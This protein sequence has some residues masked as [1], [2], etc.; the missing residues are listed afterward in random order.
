MS[1][2]KHP[3]PQ[4]LEDMR[5]IYRNPGPEWLKDATGTEKALRE[6]LRDKPAEFLERLDRLEREYQRAVAAREKRMQAAV[7]RR[8]SQ[9]T[10]EEDTTDEGAER[11]IAL[12]ED[13]LR[14]LKEKCERGSAHSEQRIC[15]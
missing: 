5:F 12:C 8:R 7:Q 6:L 3:V 13:F 4:L 1:K 14:R 15:E 2:N 10:Q 11:A 9:K